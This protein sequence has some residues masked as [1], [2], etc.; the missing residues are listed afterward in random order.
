MKPPVC[1]RFPNVTIVASTR[2]YTITYVSEAGPRY[3]SA[4]HIGSPHTNYQC[5]V[6]A[7]RCW[8]HDSTPPEPVAEPTPAELA[9]HTQQMDSLQG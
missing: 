6:I 2:G 5:A 3:E 4:Y 9:R 7:A 8:P 1:I